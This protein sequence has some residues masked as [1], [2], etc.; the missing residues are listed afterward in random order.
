M[1]KA[2]VLA[3]GLFA[4]VSSAGIYSQASDQPGNQSFFSDA[5]AGQFF[6]QRMAD[7]FTLS[8]DATAT[9]VRWWGG[10]Q[11][12]QFA[13]IDNMAS[14]TVVLYEAGISGGPGSVIYSDTVT[15]ESARLGLS[16]TG[17]TLFGGG[18]EYEYTLE[19]EGTVALSAGTEY[20]IS[21]G[22]TLVNGGADAWVWSGSSVGDL[23]NA[24]DF[25]SGGGYTVFDPT[26][27]DLAFEIIP[28][29]STAVM[30]IGMLGLGLRRRR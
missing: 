12:F 15:D 13:D 2:C 7:N 27:N 29:P 24:T 14:Y 11:N 21:V 8:A 9:S 4:G 1:K 19:L 28:A 30:G 5:V 6:S 3:L 18:I 10:S 23:V 20:W 26:F 16:Q 17:A 22:A 25:F